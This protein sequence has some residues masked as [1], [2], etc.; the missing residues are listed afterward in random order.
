MTEPSTVQANLAHEA[1]EIQ[2]DPRSVAAAVARR[3][4][5]ENIARSQRAACW[6][7]KACGS[8]ARGFAGK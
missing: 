5:A 6:G 1:A 3:L 4:R 7:S 8:I 2:I